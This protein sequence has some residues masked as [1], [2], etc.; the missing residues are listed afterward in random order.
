MKAKSTGAKVVLTVTK[1]ILHTILNIIFYA[2]VIFLVMKCSTAAFDFAYQIFGDVSVEE[3]PG[4]DIKVTIKKGDSTMKIADKLERKRV[5]ANK[6]SFYIRA[7]ITKKIILPGTFV[8]N[9]SMNYEQLL[10]IL[11]VAAKKEQEEN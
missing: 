8:L 7:K 9:N 5:I 3:E 6:Y 2:L 1:M 10:D 11:T 4:R